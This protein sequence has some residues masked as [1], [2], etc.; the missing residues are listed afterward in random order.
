LTYI[1]TADSM[2]LCLLLFTQL[3][4]KVKCPES[5]NSGQKWIL[6]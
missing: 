3:F 2:A 5:R 1:S 6:T 4:I